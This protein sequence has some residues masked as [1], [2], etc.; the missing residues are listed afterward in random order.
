MRGFWKP[1]PRTLWEELLE[2]HER[3]RAELLRWEEDKGLPPVM[4]KSASLETLRARVRPRAGADDAADRDAPDVQV[5]GYC[6]S[7]MEDQESDAESAACDSTWWAHFG[8]SSHDSDAESAGPSAPMRG[9]RRRARSDSMSEGSSVES[10]SPPGSSSSES[11]EDLGEV[12][13]SS[14][15]EWDGAS[16]RGL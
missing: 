10:S 4:K 8:S 12:D 15:G 13:S 1:A 7:S 14:N 16:E 6:S 9:F 2:R 11:W 3:E 5:G